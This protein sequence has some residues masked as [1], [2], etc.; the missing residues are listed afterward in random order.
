MEKKS[1]KIKL[2]LILGI[3]VSLY[4][5]FIGLSD[6]RNFIFLII[7]FISLFLSIGIFKGYNFSD[8]EIK[9]SSSKM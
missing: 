4:N 5:L 3:F 8:N 7:G 6:M 1:I 9:H 2:L